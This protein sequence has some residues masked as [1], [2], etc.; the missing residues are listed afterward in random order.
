MTK[1]TFGRA[2]GAGIARHFLLP[3]NRKLWKTDLREMSADWAGERVAGAAGN[4]GDG[5]F[6][7]SGG[8]RTPL[9]DGTTVPTLRG[10]GTARS[11][12]PSPA[13]WPTFSSGGT[14]SGS[15]RK[16]DGS[17]CETARHSAGDASSARS[18]C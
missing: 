13:D 7:R 2:F 6:A 10:A 4:D 1:S 18:H 8:R 9:R 11:S 16:G 15:I 14:W 3:Y 5:A 17:P 12:R